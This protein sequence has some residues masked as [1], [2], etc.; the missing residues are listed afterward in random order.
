MISHRK[1]LGNDFEWL[2]ILFGRESEAD[3]CSLSVWKINANSGL[4]VPL[5]ALHQSLSIFLQLIR[6]KKRERAILHRDAARLFY[7]E[8]HCPHWLRES[9]RESWST[10]CWHS[11]QHRHVEDLVNCI[12]RH[13]IILCVD[14]LCVSWI[15]CTGGV[16]VMSRLKCAALHNSVLNPQRLHVA[17]HIKYMR[18]LLL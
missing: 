2:A 17:I 4:L 7:Q 9:P 16:G 8:L 5:Q 11:W 6:Q 12:K 10:T 18:I 15:A 13:F 3:G 14:S 1:C